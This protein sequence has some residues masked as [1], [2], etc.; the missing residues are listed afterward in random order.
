MKQIHDVCFRQ[1]ESG[2]PPFPSQSISD[3]FFEL[4]DRIQAELE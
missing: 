2:F 1:L 4:A 3:I